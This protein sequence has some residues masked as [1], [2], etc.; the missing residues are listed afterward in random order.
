MLQALEGDILRMTKL[1]ASKPDSQVLGQTEFQIRDIVHQ[2]GAKAIL[3]GHSTR[4]KKLPRIEHDL[5]SHCGE[6]ATF[7]EHRDKS[8]ITLLGDV[9]VEVRPYYSCDHC[10]H[11]HFPGDSALGLTG[12]RMSAGAE[13]VVTLAGTLTSFGEAATKILPKMTGIRIGESTVERITEGNGERLGQFWEQGRTLGPARDW[14]WN[15]DASGQRLAYVSVDATGVGQQGPRGAK[16]EGKMVYVGM[17][18]NPTRIRS[19]VAPRRA[20]DRA[21]AAT[22]PD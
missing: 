20:T 12:R 7:K 9:R 19:E 2:I 11:G 8:F 6:V 3:A 5:S 4:Q 17:V 15:R 21:S 18:F 16:A 10:H 22:W 14:D 1:L 13:E